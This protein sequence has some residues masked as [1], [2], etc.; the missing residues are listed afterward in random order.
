MRLIFAATGDADAGGPSADPELDQAGVAALYTADARRPPPGRPWLALNMITSVDGATA[1][2]GRSGGLAG[3]ADRVVFH[4]LRGLA[5]VVVAGAGTVRTENYGPSRP[6]PEVIA[7]RLARGQ[8]PR[9]RIAVISGRLALEPGS[10]LFAELGPDDPR[11]LV[12]TV[13]TADA[14]RR[15]ALAEVA[16]VVD[17][18]ESHVDPARALAVLA[19]HGARFALCE[20]GPTLNGTLVAAGLVDEL[21]LTLA[22]MVV[23]GDSARLAHGTAPN[24]PLELDLGHVLVDEGELL[25]RYARA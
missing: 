5:D 17:A 18:G 24:A 25:L 7:A 1:V 23:A 4:T 21:C 3:V 20:G 13:A 11:P 9:P 19:D 10:R 16:D 12:I 15:E 14:G 22:P 6:A 2:D 8:A